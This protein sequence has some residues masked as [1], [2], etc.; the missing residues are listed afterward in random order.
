MDLKKQTDIAVSDVILAF[1]RRLPLWIILF[2]L[3]GAAVMAAHYFL[4][5]HATA[6]ALV[7]FS[8]DGIESGR[9]PSGNRFDEQEIKSEDRIRAA[10]DALSLVV[11]EEEIP[12]IQSAISI[13]GVVPPSVFSR[14]VDYHSVFGD[15]EV[16][17]PSFG[18]C[19]HPHKLISVF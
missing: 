1:F 19:D 2:L 8:Y 14:I 3:A 5:D 18:I 16:E 9:D 13:Q 12:T 15:D 11:T 4:T 10:A 7:I 6:K 17:L